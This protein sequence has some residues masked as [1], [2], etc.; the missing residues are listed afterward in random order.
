MIATAVAVVLIILLLILMT[1]RPMRRKSVPVTDR[2]A[3]TKT[4]EQPLAALPLTAWTDR[5]VLLQRRGDWAT[6]LEELDAVQTRNAQVYTQKNV[7]YLH[8]RAA[9]EANEL[10]RARELLAP[11]VAAGHPLRSRALI[12][13]VDLEVASGDEAKAAQLREEAIFAAP[14]HRDRAELIESQLAWLDEEADQDATRRFVQRIYASASS[15]LRRDLDARLVQLDIAEKRYADAVTRGAKLLRADIRGDAA[16]RTFRALDRPEIIATLPADLLLI[17]GE[18]AK[19]HR[20]FDRAVPILA[21][22]RGKNPQQFDELTFSIGRAQFGNEKYSDARTTY[23]GG[24]SQTKDPKWKST[25]LFHASRCAQLEGDDATA[26][27]LMTESLAVKGK[28]PSTAAALTQ[29]LRTRAAQ[30]KFAASQQ[31]LELARKLFPNERT[32][33]EG[34]LA[35]AV[36]L[37]AAGRT[38]QADAVLDSIPLAL[39]DP[40]DKAEITYWR[41]RAAELGDVPRAASLYLDVLRAPVSTHFAYFARER[42]ARQPLAGAVAAVVKSRSAEVERLVAAREWDKAREVQTDVVLLSAAPEAMEKLRAIY[43]EIPSYREVLELAPAAFPSI[44]SAGESL[45][46]SLMALGLFDETV[47]AIK[48]KYPLGQRETTL[49]QAIALN[50]AGESKDSI[51]A[52]EILMKK[53][54]GDFV[55]ELLPRS[56]LELLYPRYFYDTITT[57]AERHDADPRLVLS[58]MREESRFNPRAKSVAAARGLLQFIITTARDVGQSLGIVELDPEDLYDPRTIIRLGAKYIGDLLE[59]FGGNP[60]HS[61]AAYNAGPNQ[62]KLWKRLAPGAENDYFLT[63]VNFDETK[64]YVRKVLNSYWRYGEIYENARPPAGTR[65]EP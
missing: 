25:F 44:A 21:A 29:R 61:A 56:L 51:L 16:D 36:A 6:L 11:F 52:A 22:A 30:K 55:P 2:P 14:P 38:A 35:Y 1:R 40:Y 62:T 63:S 20:H 45:D 10:D 27:R 5:M 4:A 13:Q 7:A 32:I 37:H 53:V 8:A 57:E 17:L 43:R 3:Q 23:L 9:L 47:A 28:F 58:I 46:E 49:A 64:H 65:A 59:M 19:E 24:A 33:L 12:H 31:D 39:R 34:S 41:A 18:T 60:Y 42:L 15:D 54:P 26:E 50:R 48:S